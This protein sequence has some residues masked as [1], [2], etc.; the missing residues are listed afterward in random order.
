VQIGDWTSSRIDET[1][2]LTSSYP[3]G[4]SFTITGQLVRIDH[5]KSKAPKLVGNNEWKLEPMT[6]LVLKF[7]QDQAAGWTRPTMELELP[8]SF[9]V[10]T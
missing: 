3:D 10:D 9:E 5:G 8:S 4:T 1:I 2:T 6:R 7:D